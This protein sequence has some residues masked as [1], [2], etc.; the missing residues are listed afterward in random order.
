[1]RILKVTVLFLCG[2]MLISGTAFAY[3]TGTTNV[4][5]KDSLKYSN[6]MSDSSYDNE[7]NWVQS[8]LGTDYFF[9]EADTYN[10]TSVNWTQTEEDAN[11]YA[12]G[13]QGEPSY[14]FIKIGLGGTSLTNSHHLYQNLAE[15]AYAV[16]DITEWG[17][18][19]KNINIG[20]ISHVGEVG[21]T[22]VPE[23]A[24]ILLLG[25]GLIGIAGYSRRKFRTS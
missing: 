4:G 5:G 21:G 11:V 10:V 18:T 22:S 12:L 2:L 15:L 23:P 17:A 16:V 24:T 1:M 8:M 20:R 13:L 9:E 19:G 3:Y 6:Y 14:F 7:L 25:A